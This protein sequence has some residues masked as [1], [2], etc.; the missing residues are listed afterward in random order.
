M[1]AS[2]KIIPLQTNFLPKNIFHVT[3]G[4][5]G[6]IKEFKGVQ[7]EG[8]CPVGINIFSTLSKPDSG[9]LTQ[10]IKILVP[11]IEVQLKYKVP[12]YSEPKYVKAS[13]FQINDD[14]FIREQEMSMSEWEAF[15]ETSRPQGTLIRQN[16]AAGCHI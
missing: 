1:P 15:I 6:T 12:I 10:A 7:K 9:K 13:L 14:I 3:M 16:K 5:C 8:I 2:R 11:G 4:R